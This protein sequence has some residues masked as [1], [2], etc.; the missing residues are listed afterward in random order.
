[1][2]DQP[3]EHPPLWRNRDF[4]LLWGSQTLS[5]VG[6][7]IS[8]LALPLLVLGLTGSAVQAGAV[9]TVGGIVRAAVRLPAGALVDRWNRR[10]VML[11]SDGV[12]LAIFA[13]LV[14][15]LLTGSVPMAA[16]YAV[17]VVE[18]VFDVFFDP[19]ESAAIRHVVPAHQ[20]TE[21]FA[22]NEVRQYGAS[23]AGPPL[24]GLL[25]GLGRAVP[26]LADAVT[27]AVSFVAVGLIRRPLQSPREPREPSTS[28]RD[29][30]E[31]LRFQLGEPF[32]RAVLI[33]AA[34]LNAGFNGALFTIV[35]VLRQSGTPASLV[36]LTQG[37]AAVGGLLGALVAT[38]IVRRI[39]ARAIIT[40]VCWSA[41]ALLAVAAPL[42][43]HVGVAAPLALAF[44]VAP[45][46]NAALF[47]YQ[48]AITPDRL[49]ARV[50]SVLMLVATS[51]A[52]L[53]PLVSGTLITRLG[54]AVAM[55]FFAALM[56]VSALVAT[57]AGGIR[58]M[59]P[60]EQIGV[61]A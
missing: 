9:G 40:I 57:F 37:I 16:I 7:Y 22:R 28:R 30:V 51:P 31:G 27:F 33:L 47:S 23:L 6:G 8:I 32:L 36:G 34:P 17:A 41:A 59:Q 4:T 26:F 13:G 43:H 61:A 50:S 53:A 39:S 10:T 58:R 18:A 38:R 54:G 46:A 14:G 3:A 5:D 1:M 11:V 24:G 15:W 42:V 44:L 25:Y 35:V 55:T 20:L 48:T 21:A 12:R 19:A 52:A 2:T 60:I 56:L 49:Q 45:A 29:V